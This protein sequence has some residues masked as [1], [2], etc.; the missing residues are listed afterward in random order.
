MVRSVV[1]IN[2]ECFKKIIE[3]NGFESDYGLNIKQT[4]TLLQLKLPRKGIY[5]IILHNLKWI[6]IYHFE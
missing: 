5:I 6:F 3:N 1:N 2:K 4:N